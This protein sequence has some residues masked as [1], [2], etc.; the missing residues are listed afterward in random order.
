MLTNKLTPIPVAPGVYLPVLFDFDDWAATEG[1][2]VASYVLDS[3]TGI[4]VSDDSR[5]GNEVT[6]W[7]TVADSLAEGVRLTVTCTVTGTGSP[8]RVDTRGAL[9]VVTRL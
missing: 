2:S 1:V 4:T 7:I 9:F 3:E 6:A 8:A 5:V